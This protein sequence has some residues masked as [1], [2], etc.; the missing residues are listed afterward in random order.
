[1]PATGIFKVFHNLF[2]RSP[3]L[4]PFSDN[5]A[6]TISITGL[7]EPI[8]PDHAYMYKLIKEYMKHLYAL[9]FNWLT[10]I[11]AVEKLKMDFLL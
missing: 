2:D 3:L 7:R 6:V 5:P 10:I 8:K 1:L 11:V 4:L 9:Y